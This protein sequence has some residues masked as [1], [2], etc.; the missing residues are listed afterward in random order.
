MVPQ[1]AAGTRVPS[2]AIATRLR[3]AYQAAALLRAKDSAGVV[4]ARSQ[5]M[6]PQLGSRSGAPIG[7]S[8]NE[9]PGPEQVSPM[10]GR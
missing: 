3:T 9:T 2:N 10:L 1:W 7:V 6:N 8:H 5:G 4:Q